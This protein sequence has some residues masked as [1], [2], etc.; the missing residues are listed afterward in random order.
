MRFE[1]YLLIAAVLGVIAVI[2]YQ[3]SGNDTA[4]NKIYG[5]ALVLGFTDREVDES[6]L[7][8]S[9]QKQDLTLELD[10]SCASDQLDNMQQCFSRKIKRAISRV[11]RH[12]KQL[13]LL[14]DGR[15]ASALIGLTQ[16][17]LKEIAAIMLLQPDIDTLPDDVNSGSKLILISDIKANP[18]TLIT[19]RKMSAVIRKKDNWVWFTQLSAGDAAL[20][21]HPV[22]SHMVSF[23]IDGPVDP[24]YKL[25]FQAESRWQQP[26]VN[27]ND[28]WA[29]H[30]FVTSHKV[31]VDIQRILRA[32]YA[33]DPG[34][35]K[36]W[37]LQR[38]HAFSLLKY[39]D[40]LPPDKQG[41]YVTFSN[42][43]GHTFYL[44]LEKYAQYEP[45][46]VIGI[47]NESNLYRFTSFY[48]TNRYYSWTPGGPDENMLYSQSLGAFLHFRK[49]LPREHELPY[50]QY[51]S[52]L[53]DT[54][55]F[56]DKNPYQQ[57][58]GLSEDAF[59]VVTLNCLPC[60]SIHGKG[61]AAH[62]LDYLNL[63]PQPGFAKPLTSYPRSVLD[64]FFFNQAETAKLIGVNINYVET[65]IGRELI[66]WL[67]PE[68][69]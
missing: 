57:I 62:H 3:L 12:N 13:I 2:I 30:E 4:E 9:W 58:T 45:E 11:Q 14:A 33:H 31:T 20:L 22:L 27:N 18:D 23:A 46:F 36:Q 5:R 7:S 28:F 6:L 56:T 16:K 68:N 10:Y 38:Y 40:S 29:Q 19:L 61:G 63:Q 37:E 32:F 43:K 65:D 17:S 34:Q 64:N 67:Q 15:Q 24:R 8:T 47:D 25:E 26:I 60:H 35:L 54:I 50:L 66:G 42:R 21:A 53:F 44:D 39:R 49:A 59:R 1:K 69:D 51:S 55:N 48:I 41:R 52:I